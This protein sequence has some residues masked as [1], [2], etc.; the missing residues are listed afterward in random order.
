MIDLRDIRC[1]LF[2]EGYVRM[3]SYQF[4][5]SQESIEMPLIHLTNNAV[6]SMDQNYGKKEE[7]NQLSFKDATEKAQKE[8]IKI[9]FQKF[10]ETEI[11]PI[12]EMTFK[13][14]D[15]G[16]M[17]PNQRRNTFEILGYDFM[18][19][20]SLRPWLI[21]VNTNPCL[22]ETSKLLRMYIP[23]MVDDAFKL[24]IDVVF[25]PIVN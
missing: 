8:G 5:L 18:I 20:S 22:E 14:V 7:G 1:Y 12:V 17:N 13:C 15:N 23:R 19:D 10:L 9:D 6:Q 25:P 11:T 16:K 3:S 24:T 21:E 2:R 4:N